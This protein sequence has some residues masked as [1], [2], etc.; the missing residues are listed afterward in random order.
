LRLRYFFAVSIWA[1]LFGVLYFNI[2]HDFMGLV[3][4]KLFPSFYMFD[5]LF[6]STEIRLML[7]IFLGSLL[8]GVV[9]FIVFA[10][11]FF[12]NLSKHSALPLLFSFPV[13]FALISANE[14][15]FDIWLYSSTYKFFMMV[16]VL[17]G[18]FKLFN[19]INE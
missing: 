8:M 14:R 5:F 4:G 11:P 19:I 9:F 13:L 17:L 6:K 3:I 12:K 2:S 18:F 15:M 16:L 7:D 10:L 1:V